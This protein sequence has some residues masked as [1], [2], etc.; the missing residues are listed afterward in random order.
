MPS[1]LAVVI[2]QLLFMGR[3][4][5]IGRVARGALPDR[6]AT[7]RELRFAHS[8]EWGAGMDLAS[9][10]GS[11]GEL[12]HARLAARLEHIAMLRFLYHA[13]WTKSG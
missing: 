9:L 2:F 8:R 7:I 12:R 1:W 3:H 10:S 4:P 6:A 11:W 13:A 5:L